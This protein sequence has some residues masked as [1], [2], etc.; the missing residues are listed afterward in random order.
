MHASN[1][2]RRPPV[3]IVGVGALFP[4]SLG[5]GAFWRNILDGT[6]LISDVPPSAWRIEDYY[7]PD[8][9]A[10]DKTYAKRGGFLPPVP[11]DPLG[12]G[13]PPATLPATDTAQLLALFVARQVLEDASR[14]QFRE[15]DR[16]RI[17][18]ILGVASATELVVELGSRIQR[19]IWANAMRAAGL[20][21]AQVQDICNRIANHYVPWQEA[22]FPG[23]LGNVVAGRIAN[24]LDL[25]GTNAVT[26]AACASSFAALEMGLNELYLGQSDLVIAGG[27]DAINDIFMYMCFSKTPALS[28]TGDCRPFSDQADG[29]LLGEGIGMFALRRLEDAERDGNPIYAVIRGLGAS[30][31]GRA[32]SIYGPKPE[33][34]MLALSRAYEAAGYSPATVEMVEAHGTGTKAGDLAEVTALGRVFTEADA[35]R[36]GWCAVGSVKSQ[37]GHTKAAAGAAGLF[38][39]VMALHHKVLPPTVKVERPAAGLDGAAGPFYVN[40]HARPWISSGDHPRRASVSSFG[41]GGSNFHVT[42]EEYEG[43]GRVAARLPMSPIALFLVSAPTRADLAGQARL[44]ANTSAEGFYAKARAT[45]IGFAP[46]GAVRAAIVA[47]SAAD[48]AATAL[49][50]ADALSSGGAVSVPRVAFA[51]GSATPGKLAFL[52]PGQGSQYVGMG[53]DVAMA[54]TGARRVWDAASEPGDDHAVHGAVFPPPARSWRTLSRPGS[55]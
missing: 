29:T 25:G 48:L 54:F 9:S 55:R 42:L 8:P 47:D 33:G 21:E 52:F 37:I 2:I 5:A 50:F 35:D 6:D 22:S 45:Q 49:R 4:G 13:I 1:P 17:S 3:A 7:D 40:T 18:V 19:P 26:D 27:V 10:P 20:A 16:R 24:R 23:L 14:G 41:F 44:L 39:A 32:T 11:F 28:P 12:F 43:E 31:D 30:S 51:E 53:A 36:R 34:Q 46:A 15:V 38:K